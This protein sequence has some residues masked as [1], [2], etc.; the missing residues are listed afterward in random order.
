MGASTPT[1]RPAAAPPLAAATAA[2]T[3][4]TLLREAQPYLARASQLPDEPNQFSGEGA[5]ELYHMRFEQVLPD[6]LSASVV[7]RVFQLRD[8]AAADLFAL[9]DLWYD[10]ARSRFQLCAAE[11]LRAGPKPGAM[12]AISGQDLGDLRPGASGNQPRHIGLPKLQAGDRI[13][14]LYLLMPDTSH[15]WR[16]LQGHYL[17]NL[18]A[19]RDS[20]PTLHSR[21]VVASASPLTASAVGVSP[22]LRSRDANGQNLWEWQ[23]GA[24]PAF[25]SAP[26]GP[27]ITDRS[28]FVQVSGFRSWSEMAGWYS[29]LL[30]RQSKL[31]PAIE[32]RLLAIA[33]KAAL[34]QPGSG[35][36]ARETVARVWRYLAP[37][38]SY[39]GDE[40]GE[41]A[42][43]PAA[44]ETVFDR[45][46][47]DC[48]DGALL[49][50]TW[51]RAAGVE[52]DLALVRT[53]AMGQLAPVRGDG[54]AA[55]TMAA[56]DHA[57]VYVPLTQQ[58]IDT[59]APAYLTD[60]LPSSD[61]D[62]L[63]L[64]VR[65]GQQ[66]LVRVPSAPAWANWTRRTVRLTPMG[67]GSLEAT[68]AIIV[69]GADA[70]S[71]RQDYADAAHQRQQLQDW[72]RR[73]FAGA[74]VE[75][76][77]V[78]GV[79]PAAD[80][81]EIAF[82]AR[83]PEAAARSSAWVRRHYAQSLAFQAERD[84][85]LEL[86]LRWRLDETWTLDQSACTPSPAERRDSAFGSMEIDTTCS[87]GALTVHSE[88]TQTA[89]QIEPADYAAFRGFWQGVDAALNAPVPAATVA[90]ASVAD[91]R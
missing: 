68:G 65:A 91:R 27:S 42:Y 5:V 67:D 70:P 44:V 24:L 61:Q 81:V 12:T 86:P 76:M 90:V 8:N 14:V 40:R 56:F 63:A 80:T 50:A 71:L 60:E 1:L 52:A 11:V 35:E 28:P 45:G 48:K 47:G 83:V 25:F 13:S 17:G 88:V 51:L 74:G 89:R 57:L 19:F 3:A 37:R 31:A 10:S 53:P 6:G 84:I 62:S 82:R 16:V 41:H 18:F 29:N 34:R 30:A 23:A 2:P 69:S 9:D 87:G 79:S 36:A 32:Q 75:S 77:A 20:F 7:Q 15:D 22:A 58:W 21:Y 38:L 54:V 4:A 46:Q 73:T 59:T 85:P 33:G 43:V 39:R 66:A 49:L 26:D 64:I 78:T 55:A 72:L